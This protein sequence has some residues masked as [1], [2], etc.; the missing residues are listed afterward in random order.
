VCTVSDSA[1]I[2][3]KVSAYFEAVKATF[4]REVREVVDQKIQDPLLRELAIR[5]YEYF[6]KHGRGTIE[7]NWAWT[8]AEET[9]YK[10]SPVGQAAAAAVKAVKEEFSKIAKAEF[11]EKEPPYRLG[12]VDKARSLDQQIEFWNLQAKPRKDNGKEYEGLTA[13]KVLHAR[14]RCEL[15]DLQKYANPAPDGSIPTESLAKFRQFLRRG[16]V[17]GGNQP[18]WATPGLSDHGRLSAYD[19]TI[20]S[21]KVTEFGTSRNQVSKWEQKGGPTARSWAERLQSAVKNAAPT[22]FEGPL[23]SPKEPWH[24]TYIPAR[25]IVLD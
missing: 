23:Q 21:G 1:E 18:S 9:R 8:E 13:A 14:A 10:E 22:D 25:G 6:P 4:A 2:E 3:E 15:A 12:V 19:F 7:H 16:D 11:P 5:G 17:L 24:Y 20:T